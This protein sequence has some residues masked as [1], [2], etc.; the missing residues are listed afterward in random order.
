MISSHSISSG[1]DYVKLNWTH[2]KFQPERYQMKYVC[3]MKPAC[4]PRNDTNHYVTTKT[5]SISWETTFVTVSNLRPSSKCMLFLVAVYNPASI[6]TGI[7]ITGTTLDEDAINISSGL[8][9]FMITTVFF[10]LSM[11]N[12]QQATSIIINKYQ[13]YCS[14]VAMDK[15]CR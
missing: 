12:E 4:T 9:N 14:V 2:P 13:N 11:C 3:T 15:I 5:Q 10:M 1:P 7:A 8:H 6:D